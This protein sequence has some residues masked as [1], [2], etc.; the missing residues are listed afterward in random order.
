VSRGVAAFGLLAVLLVIVV[1][2][3]LSA[4]PPRNDPRPR[5]VLLFALP[6]VSWDDLGQ[7]DLPNL[8]SWLDRAAVAALTTRAEDR[9]THLGDGY[10]TLGAGTRAIGDSA[11]DGDNLEFDEPFG[12]ATAGDAYTQRT[13]RTVRHGIVSLTDPRVVERNSN[14][15]YDAEIGA[16][17]V[18]LRDA[19]FRRA[20]VANG[21]GSQP[22]TP[23]SPSS[24]ELRRQAVLALADPKGRLPAGRVDPRLLR[25]DPTAPYGVRLAE[26]AVI[27]AFSRAWRAKSVVLVEA[28]DLV[29]EDVFR[30]FATPVH[31]DFMLRD[32]LR[33]SDHL[34]GELL[35]H[36]DPKRDA[37]MVLGPA[38]SSRTI[39]LTVLGIQAPGVSPGLL[40]SAT[41]RRSGFVQLI[42]I[43]PTILDLVGVDR[44]TSMEGRAVEVGADGG[45]AADRRELL[46][47][48]D[49]A[50]QF[51][52]QRV[53]EV[54]VAF[55][56]FAAALVFGT[57]LVYRRR[58]PPWAAGLLGRVALCV[59]AFAPATFLARLLPLD[60][61]GFVPYWAYLVAVSIALGWLYHRAGRSNPVD[62][63]IVA[64]L[65]MV[66]L[67]VGDVLLGSHL[68]FNS[69][70]GYSP[71][72]AGR[73]V[74][75]SN[76]AYAA[77]AA[78][79]VLVAPLL[80]RRAG[81]RRGAC[82]AIALL[83][84][85]I[86]VDGMP[87]WGSDVGGILSMVPAFAITSVLILG[88]KV[89]WRTVLWS[90]IGLVA[91]V[92]VFT[93]L[94]L[95]R[96]PERRTHLGRLVER[97]DERGLGDFIVVLERKLTDNLA[98]LTHSVWGFMLPIT[99]FVI[100]WALRRAPER[101]RAVATAVPEVR[102]A[103]IGFAILAV[104]GYMLNDS[105][106]AIPGLMLVIVIAC[107]VWLLTRIEPRPIADKRKVTKA[108]AGASAR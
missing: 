90:V 50:A 45:S 77:M 82:L 60:Q 3:P 14:L 89:R 46:V 97:I 33:R 107:G 96:S 69:A 71:T 34:F 81:G 2:T 61:A 29:R 99:L 78:S 52:D 66:V 5:R 24:S 59:L 87:F 43:A 84:V 19:G 42:D 32:A 72:V 102:V 57:V 73:F 56:A 58:R 25:D 41:T 22:D 7:F 53:G 15:L 76:P 83:A 30:P 28:S 104:L 16:L 44:P 75:F 101:L 13:G 40:R 91:A 70:L 27:S 31:R 93:G 98:T 106:I 47:R 92:A 21:D 9:S 79:S 51:R 37:V 94:D 26:G 108:R 55:V 54:Q 95:S 49:E 105:G 80:A 67:L 103:G 64:L 12:R 62:A 38:H 6:H 1:A 17:A 20:V 36:V 39:T 65:V 74:G 35:K 48:A 63:L 23:P 10:V 85:A 4:A 100:W 68:Q 88:R 86:I 18:A 11:T 8:N